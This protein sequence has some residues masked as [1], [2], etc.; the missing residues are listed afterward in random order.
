MKNIFKFLTRKR[1][2]AEL[3]K[4]DDKLSKLDEIHLHFRK[5]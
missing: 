3:E 5:L 1:F 2:E 4:I